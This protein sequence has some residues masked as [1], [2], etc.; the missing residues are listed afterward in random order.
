MAQE[1]DFKL[2]KVFQ[3]AVLPRVAVLQ[4]VATLCLLQP[5]QPVFTL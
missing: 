3:S 5:F 4:T 2:V 1:K